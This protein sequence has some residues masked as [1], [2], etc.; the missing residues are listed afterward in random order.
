[1]LGRMS[2]RSGGP[3]DTPDDMPED[4]PHGGHRHGPRRGRRRGFR[5]PGFGGPGF[6]GFPFDPR[7]G[8]PPGPRRRGRKA[9]RGDIRAAV[10]ALLAEQ[11][12]HGYQIIQEIAE[13]TGGVW[14][15][16]P[17]SVYP[18]LAQ[19]EDEGLVRTEQSDGRRV[20]HL[21]DEG[22][23]YV[24]DRREELD[25]VWDSVGGDE[26]EDIFELRSAAG[27]V[28]A[29]TMQVMSAGTPA[30]R[31]AAQEV[32]AETRRKLYSILAE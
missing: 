31:A 8:F 7:M 20:M 1:M 15:P 4:E 6:G 26:D 22:T 5:G 16:S 30:Q 10:L 17:G 13:R 19:L 27:Q 28:M 21:T 11:P 32:L 23:R 18:T 3:H 25:R 24:T 2:A 12:L 9:A 14:R 29:A